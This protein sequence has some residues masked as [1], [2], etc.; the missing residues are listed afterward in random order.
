MLIIIISFYFQRE[1]F[2]KFNKIYEFDYN[3]LNSVSSQNFS[4]LKTSD[5]V[6]DWLI[7]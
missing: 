2:S 6:T 5:L 4:L 3:I 1:G 7:S